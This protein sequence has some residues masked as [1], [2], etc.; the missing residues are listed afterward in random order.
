MVTTLY[1]YIYMVWLWQRLWRIRLSWRSLWRIWLSLVVWF[2]SR[3]DLAESYQTWQIGGW[4]QP[5]PPIFGNPDVGH[6]YAFG[7]CHVEAHDWATWRP[8]IGPRHHSLHSHCHIILLRQLATSPDRWLYSLPCGCMVCHVAPFHWSTIF[9]KSPKMSDTWQPLVLPRHH[10]DIMHM[11]HVTLYVCHVYCM[12]DDVIRTGADIS[13][14]DV[15]SSLL[16]GLG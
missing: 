2:I 9:P 7:C 10:V 11:T 1:I 14:T 16:T 3:P 13:S 8:F 5:T 12:N 6:P 4:R 15:D